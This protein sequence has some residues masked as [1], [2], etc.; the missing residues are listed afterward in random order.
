MATR[1]KHNGLRK[2]TEKK[3]AEEKPKG[4]ALTLTLL[5]PVF[6]FLYGLLTL[7]A[8]LTQAFTTKLAFRTL[9]DKDKKE[10]AAGMSKWSVDAAYQM[11]AN[12][13]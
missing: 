1:D 2:L 9:S 11:R 5:L 4:M 8:F 6:Y 13:F 7:A 10:L 12:R 3:P